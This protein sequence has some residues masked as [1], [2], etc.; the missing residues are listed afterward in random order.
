MKYANNAQR[1]DQNEFTRYLKNIEKSVDNFH[2][3]NHTDKECHEKCDPKKSPN[4]EGV[5]TEVCEQ[6]FNVINKFRNCKKM[7]EG[8]FYFFFQYIFDLHNLK[9]EGKLRSIAHPRKMI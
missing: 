2:F 8:H 4:L 7:N 5:N 1:A 6:L 3:V 9:I